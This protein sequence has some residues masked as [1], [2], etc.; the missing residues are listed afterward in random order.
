MKVQSTVTPSKIKILGEKVLIRSNIV[1]VEKVEENGD[2]QILFE[3]DEVVKTKDEYIKTVSEETTELKIKVEANLKAT[4]SMVRQDSLTDTE[5]LELIDIYEDWEDKLKQ[6]DKS[7][8]VDE[9]YKYEDNLYKVMQAHTIQVDWEPD[10]VP[11][12]FTKIQP[13]GVIP[14]WVQP[15]GAQDAY[16]IGDQR[17]YNEVVYISLIDGNTTVPDGDKPYNR[18][19]DKV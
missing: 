4:R 19:W 18:Y 17:I 11:A 9:L 5:L 10:K 7:V 1:E 12:L 13:A 15:T 6:Q 16:N 2:I 3:Y 14:I 8:K